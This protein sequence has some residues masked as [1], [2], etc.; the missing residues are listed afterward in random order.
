MLFGKHFRKYYLKYLHFFIIGIFV[1]VVENYLQL[2][3]PE[4]FGNII[5]NLEALINPDIEYTGTILE[6]I[7]DY[8]PFI[9]NI[10]IFGS[11][12]VLGRFL[13]RYTIFGAAR[14][15][16]GDLR[17]VMF[18]HATTLSQSYYST[19]KVGGMMTYFINDLEAIRM[20]FGPGMLVLVDGLVLGFLA[21]RKMFIINSKLTLFALI[22]MSLLMVVMVFINKTM[23][24]KFKER[25]EVFE[26]LSDFTQESFSGIS[27]IKAYVKEMKELMFFKKKSKDLYN[28]NISYVKLMII[29][30]IAIGIALNIVIVL[31][32]GFGGYLVIYS[33]LSSGE[34]TEYISYFFTLIW[35]VM[36]LAQ[37]VMLNSQA[38]ASAKRLNEFFEQTP[39]VNDDLVTNDYEQLKGHIKA[40]NLSFKYPDSNDYV[41]KNISFEIKPGQM[42]GILGRTGSGKSTLVE[43]FLRLYNVNE[44]ELFIDNKDIMTL[45]TKDVRN[46]IGYVPQD[47]FLFSNTITSNIGFSFD[48]E[49]F[50]KVKEAAILSDV[51]INIM[52]FKEQYD[53]VLGERGVTVSG[54]QKQRISIARAL[55]K[56]PEILILDDSVSS[57]DTKTEESIINNL[58]KVREDKTTIFIAHRISTVRKMD[59]ILLL[60]EGK[61]VGMGN[62]EE[63]L[64]NNKLYQ[65]MVKLQ[66]LENMINEEEVD[67]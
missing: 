63:L 17:D 37:F 58:F 29:I 15:I 66:Q 52:D 44:N 21:A 47:N 12:I 42:I 56:D 31:I 23:T 20:A 4:I 45:K 40:Q 8:L 64:K 61:L 49:N 16:E 48:E 39:E 53:T 14:K 6:N 62:H 7:E 67:I 1:L 36:A 26:S 38:Q 50:D 57:V 35:P 60:E 19:Q 24:A 46:L 43:L 3:I 2:F 41:L 10:L 25:Q 59:L 22:P 13:W 5:D 28:K 34:L 51:D 55:A 65:E 27:V 30:Q 9:I 11:I 33:E 32:L 18:T 54:G